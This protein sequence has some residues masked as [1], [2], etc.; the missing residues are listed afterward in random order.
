MPILP[1]TLGFV[2]HDVARLLRKRFEQQARRHG[3]TRSKWQVLAYLA[4]NPG[5]QQGALAEL[6][7]VEPITLCRIIDALEAS[8]LVRRQP[9][10]TDRRIWLLHLTEAAE[11]LLET[12][13][14]IAHDARA[15]ALAGLAPT[16]QARLLEMLSK[17]R[18]NLIDAC[19]VQA[20]EP[21]HG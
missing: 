8:G 4:Q 6:L 11:P 17:M 19:H 10:A 15:D 21:A 20:Q 14:G 12:M 2:L 18:T 16:E 7:E 1:P 9:H 5:I 13:H 3:L